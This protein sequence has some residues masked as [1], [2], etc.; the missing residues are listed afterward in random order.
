M[1]VLQAVQG[2]HSGGAIPLSNA[3]IILGRH[4]ACDVV[5]ESGAVSRQHARISKID[6]DY[7]IE[8]LHSRNGTLLNGEQVA[9][10]QL[11]SDGDR[12]GICDLEFVFRLGSDEFPRVS[13]PTRREFLS[14]ALMVDDDA[15][16]RSSTI[17]SKMS[18]TSGS[19]G[20]GLEVNSESKLKALMEI[21]RNLGQALGMADVLPKLLDSLFSIFAQADRGFIVLLD[22]RT[23]RVVPKAIRHRRQDDIQTLRISRTII[24]NVMRTKEAILS[25][26]AASDSR[27][28]MAESIVDYQ[29]HSMICAPLVNR[30]GEAMGV[31]QLDTLDSRNRFGPDDL[32]LLVA[33]ACQAAFAVENAQL[34]ETALVDQS[35]RRELSVAHEVQ[36]GFLPAAAPRIPEYDFFEFYE[37]ANQLG[38]DYYDYVE[39]PG[40]RL[41]VVVADVSGKGISASLLMAKLSAE[42]RY[43][44][45]SEPDPAQAVGRLNRAFCSSLWEDRFVTMV[46]AVL[47]PRRHEATI[48]N[49]GHLPPYLRRRDGRVEAQV[50]A[51]VLRIQE[52]MGAAGI[53]L[54]QV[55]ARGQVEK[56]VAP[57][58]G[59]GLP[60][61][62]TCRLARTRLPLPTTPPFTRRQTPHA[63]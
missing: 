58:E 25:A 8:D 23:G 4:P 17:M 21:S 22:Q 3:V 10:R 59:V 43:C 57:G 13:S 6:G 27:F 53:E 34:H 56:V 24:D 5:L 32:D 19:T 38:G 47:D 20:M 29:I 41:A 40:G 54:G 50:I 31:L 52:R 37:P 39:L 63:R 18:V 51:A 14:E 28:E 62:S 16:M 44:L 9:E 36:R 60:R 61:R 55:Q 26:D 45:A 46:A 2:Q 15:P 11:L 30:E 49:A 42:T 48:V 33:V 35:L 1:A 7:Y 12:L